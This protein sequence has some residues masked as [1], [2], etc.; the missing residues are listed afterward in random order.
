MRKYRA[1]AAATT[2]LPTLVSVP[3]TN[4]PGMRSGARFMN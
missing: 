2:V 4:R 3:V 1:I